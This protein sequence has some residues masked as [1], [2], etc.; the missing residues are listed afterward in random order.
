MNHPSKHRPGQSHSATNLN[1]ERIYHCRS[2]GR[3]L[4]Y[5]TYQASFDA[6]LLASLVGYCIVVVGARLAKVPEL[7]IAQ[8]WGRAGFTSS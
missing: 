7:G 4:A 8:S 2:H 6:T 1:I 5:V 3:A